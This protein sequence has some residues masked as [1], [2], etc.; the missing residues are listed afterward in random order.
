MTQNS[1][2]LLAAILAQV[3]N[4][5][6]IG[7]ADSTQEYIAILEKVQSDIQS[8]LDAARAIDEAE[9][10][11]FLQ[12]SKPGQFTVDDEVDNLSLCFHSKGESNG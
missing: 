11:Q 7:G 4:L 12:L 3:Q 9:A 8:R 6:E 10:F 1:K 2:I 5:D